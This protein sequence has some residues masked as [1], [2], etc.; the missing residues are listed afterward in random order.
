MRDIMHR[1]RVLY[2]LPA[3]AQRQLERIRKRTEDLDAEVSAINFPNIGGDREMRS[4]IHTGQ[5]GASWQ[6]GSNEASKRSASVGPPLNHS[7]PGQ[8]LGTRATD[9]TDRRSSVDILA[10]TSLPLLLEEAS[11]SSPAKNFRQSQLDLGYPSVNTSPVKPA[12]IQRSSIGFSE[13][14]R[15]RPPKLQP[16]GWTILSCHVP[17]YGSKP[18]ML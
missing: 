1:H 17:E 7:N 4:S 8:S 2:E 18:N 5:S 13:K 10:R 16:V 9:M 3:P 12:A 6:H 14:K 11:P 15:R